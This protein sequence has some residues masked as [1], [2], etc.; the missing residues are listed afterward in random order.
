MIMLIIFIIQKP[1]KRKV[2][3]T[4]LLRPWSNVV[5][6]VLEVEFFLSIVGFL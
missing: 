3:Q 2:R 5:T 6:T 4:L 1:F